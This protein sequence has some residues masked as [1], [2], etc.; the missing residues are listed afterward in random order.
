MRVERAGKVIAMPPAQLRILA[1][2]VRHSPN[3]VTQQAIYREIWGDE[4]ADK[5]AM[6]VHM[7]A[8][9]AAVD[10]PFDLQLIQTVR[11]FGYRIAVPDA[12]V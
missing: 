11:G 12:A 8:L 10:K 1:L 4:P 6:V 5:H 3:V 2:L 9:R 7:H